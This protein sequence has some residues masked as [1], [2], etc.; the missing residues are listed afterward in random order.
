MVESSGL[1]MPRNNVFQPTVNNMQSSVGTNGI[2]NMVV[3]PV[4]SVSSSISSSSGS[5]AATTAT[6]T[7][8][9]S[10]LRT[11]VLET[12]VRGAWYRVLVTLEIDYLSVSLDESCEDHTTTLN[13][14]LGYAFSF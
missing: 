3:P 14:T 4:P 8:T 11:G 1:L 6:V 2:T 9:A 7:A 13:G 12:R 5:S 10:A